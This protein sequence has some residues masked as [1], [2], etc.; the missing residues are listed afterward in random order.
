M[1]TLLDSQADIDQDLGNLLGGV[2]RW[3][4]DGTLSQLQQLA[5]LDL[6]KQ[7]LPSQKDEDWRFTDISGIKEINWQT[8][9]RA[10]LNPEVLTQFSLL[11]AA[12][13]RIVFVN[14]VY[15]P[16]LSD[17][18]Q[19]PPGVYVGNWAGLSESE[20][21]QGREYLSSLQQPGGVFRQLNT[22][23]FQDVGVIWVKANVEIEQPIHLLYLTV[24]TERPYLMQPRTLAIA[25]SSSKVN[26][27]EQY[28]A[29]G[30]DC[31]HVPRNL[32]YYNNVVTDIWVGE[33]AAINH[34]RI[35]TESGDAWQIANTL[36]KQARDSRYHLVEI[37]LGARLSRHNLHVEQE[38]E[39]TES[40]LRGLTL[41][42]EKQ[43]ADTHSL[44]NL[45]YPHGNTSQ[46]HKCIVDDAASV[47]F[48]GKI[49]VPQAAQLTN[50]EQLNRNLL[51]SPQGRVNTKPEL[52]ITADN[53]KCTHGATI[54]QL[55][56]D[57]IFYLQSRGLSALDARHLLVDAFAAEILSHVMVDSLRKRL[58]QCVACRNY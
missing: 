55:E 54:S 16:Q 26:F 36:V 25:E 57:E 1:S 2:P 3:E 37:S 46:L 48:N 33:N 24:P 39:Q 31:S 49:L 30:L 13:T 23:G 28:A 18:S 34:N 8:P 45:Q 5:R 58:A 53:V 22:A 50:A 7:K 35:Q 27:I 41:V 6:S 44:V 43:L 19:L 29:T 56:T 47:V 20:K 10:S 51:L 52:Q 4:S 14:G 15:T 11:E 42:G 40:H 32:P 9:A 17:I 21:N 12:Q 38:G